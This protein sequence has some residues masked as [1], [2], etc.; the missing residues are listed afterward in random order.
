MLL[1][2]VNHDYGIF[3]VGNILVLFDESTFSSNDAKQF[4]CIRRVVLS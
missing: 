2:V 1:C 4:N 3:C